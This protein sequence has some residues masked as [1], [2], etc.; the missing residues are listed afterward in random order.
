[1]PVYSPTIRQVRFDPTLNIAHHPMQRRSTS[2]ARSTS[3]QYADTTAEFTSPE[4]GSLHGS[5]HNY[6]FPMEL[7]PAQMLNTSRSPATETIFV[8]EHPEDANVFSPDSVS[9]R[10]RARLRDRHL[11]LSNI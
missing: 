4:S 8:G 1:M 6:P 2:G 10:T 5:T 7:S 9:S 11:D 3:A